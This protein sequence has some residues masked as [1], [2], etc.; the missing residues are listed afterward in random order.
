M[1]LF[2][3]QNRVH[4]MLTLYKVK[5]TLSV[6]SDPSLLGRLAIFVWPWK[7]LFSFSCGCCFCGSRARYDQGHVFLFCSFHSVNFK[8]CLKPHTDDSLTFLDLPLMAALDSLVTWLALDSL[9]T[10]L[11]HF[12]SR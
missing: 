7:V 11:A 9:V 2:V 3:T 10:R 5:F 8:S 4:E 6:S 12:D 1:F